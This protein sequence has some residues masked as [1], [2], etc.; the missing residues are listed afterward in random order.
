[1]D[2]NAGLLIRG[3]E[4]VAT[5]NQR[6]CRKG[7]GPSHDTAVPLL[8]LGLLAVTPLQKRI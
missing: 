4:M 1:M 2:A 5:K 8:V 6:C 7:G 3:P